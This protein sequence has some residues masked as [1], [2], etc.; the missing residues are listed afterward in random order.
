MKVASLI[1]FL[2][3]AVDTKF[4]QGPYEE[5]GGIMLVGYPGSFKSTIVRAAVEPHPDAM[6]VSDINVKQWLKFR[7]DFITGRFS[8]LGFTDFEKIY[9]RHSSTS[10]HIEGIV[11]GLVCEGYGTGPSGDQ[12]MPTIPSRALI[13]GAMTSNCFEQRYAEWQQSGFLR[14]FLW[15][16]FAVE[17]SE[18]ITKAI[19]RWEKI[20]F[21]K[22]RVRPANKQI[23]MI[24]SKDR[25]RQIENMMK[26]QPGLQ[27]TAYIL[28]KKVV[29]VLDW[30][31]GSNNGGGKRVTEILE[32]L[33]PSLSKDG[34]RIILDKGKD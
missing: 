29:S 12:R 11:K 21:G 16:V 9:Q 5:R 23:P 27:G 7:E 22:I 24:L 28:M 26:Y 25:S 18:E 15:I 3:A 8:A 4:V 2:D 20:D 10:S 6:V 34:G 17:N 32:D 13:I 14:R 31:Y 33:A 19:R 30:K 1:E